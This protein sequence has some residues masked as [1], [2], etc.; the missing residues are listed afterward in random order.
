MARN[1]ELLLLRSVENLG[2][3]GD[4]VKVKRGFARNYL[5]PL[6]LAEVPTPTR[7]RSLETDRSRALAELKALRSAREELLRRMEGIKI[8]MTRAC[9]DQ[10]L[11]YGSVSQRDVAD[12]LAEMGYDVGVRAVRMATAARRIG[13]YEVPLVLDKDLRVEVSLII[14]PDHPLEEATPPPDQQQQQAPRREPAVE[15]VDAIE[16]STEEP[17]KG[18]GRREKPDTRR[19]GRRR[20]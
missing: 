7:I 11:L 4:I 10:G 19:G 13:T 18:R 2:I 6:G 20:E 17:P 16:T 14:H 5:R 9:N 8:E 3:V 1:V 12:A 15:L